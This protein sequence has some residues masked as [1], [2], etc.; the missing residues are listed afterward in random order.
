VPGVV[1]RQ[2]ASESLALATATAD[3]LPE[4]HPVLPGL[5][6]AATEQAVDVWATHVPWS[7]WSWRWGDGIYIYLFM[8]Y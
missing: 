1:Q 4:G 8:I 2:L 6:L 3:T 7:G 5:G